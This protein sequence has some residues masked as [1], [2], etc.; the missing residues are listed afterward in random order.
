MTQ[1]ASIAVFVPGTAKPQGS[2][3]GRPIY[4]GSGATKTFTGKVAQVE[5][6]GEPLK[7]WRTDL[8]AALLTGAGEPLT[9][10]ADAPVAVRLEFWMARPKS[11][12]RTGRNSHALRYAAPKHPAG[13]PDVDKLARAVLDAITSAGVWRD[14]SL[15]VD[16]HVSKRL[17]EIGETPGCHIRIEALS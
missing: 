12:Y 11:H 6:A 5:S 3:Q 8:R 4:R 10:L 13:K 2:K 9:N 7:E 15:V 16:L 1:P 14:D 17:A